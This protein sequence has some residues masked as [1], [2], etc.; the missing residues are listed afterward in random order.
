MKKLLAAL[1]AK[2]ILI[3]AAIIAVCMLIWFAGPYLS[4]GGLH[5]FGTISMRLT[6]IILI[7]ALVLFFL[8][9][10]PMSIIGMTVSCLLLWHASPLLTLGSIQPFAS[11]W[12]RIPLLIVI[13]TAYMLIVLAPLWQNLGWNNQF[14]QRFLKHKTDNIAKNELKIVNSI[15]QHAMAQLKHIRSSSTGFRRLFEGRKY[16]YELPWYM[17]IGTPGAGKTTALINSGMKFPLTEQMQASANTLTHAG[18]GG[19]THCDWWFTNDAVLIDTAGRY[20]S[21]EMDKVKDNAEWHGFLSMLRKRRAQSPINGAIVAISL[22][23]FL[24]QTE[25]E[26]VKHAQLLRERLIELRQEL[27]IRFPV[28][29]M[30]TKMDL[31]T[32]FSEYFHHL[33][34]E[35]LAQVWGFTL[36]YL[37]TPTKKHAKKKVVETTDVLPLKQR[38]QNE[39]TALEKRLEE[40][41]VTRLREEFDKDRRC[42]LYA[43]P[44]EFNGMSHALIQMIESIFT[45]SRFDQ[46]HVNQG[47]RGVYFTSAAQATTS[48]PANQ[49]SLLQRLH[50]AFSGNK[51]E[52]HDPASL[53]PSHKRSYFLS[54]L[55]SRI[56]IPDAHLVRPNLR[57]ELRFRLLRLISHIGIG[58][59]AL[60]L[61]S[62]F[63]FSFDKNDA[64]LTKVATKVAALQPVIDQMERRT[65]Y[66]NVPALSHALSMINQL[67]LSTEFDIHQPPHAV[68]YGL[69]SAPAIIEASNHLYA[70]TQESLLIPQFIH[71]LEDV[72][73]QAISTKNVTLAYDTLRVY[74]QLHQRDHFNAD[75]MK[76]WAA[77]DWPLTNKTALFGPQSEAMQH[78][79]KLFSSHRIVQSTTAPNSQLIQQVRSLLETTS[80]APHLYRSLKQHLLQAHPG[81]F[82]LSQAIG[83]EAETLFK[84][85]S[86]ALLDQSM[87]HIFTY[88]GF[89]NIIQPA[90]DQE[91]QRTLDE[92]AWLMGKDQ[93]LPATKSLVDNLLTLYLKEYATQWTHYLD[94]LDIVANHDLNAD[95]MVLKTMIKSSSPLVLLSRI[96]AHQTTLSVDISI[97]TD[98]HMFARIASQ[99][100]RSLQ[101]E[102]GTSNEDQKIKTL[103]DNQFTTLRE[104]V[105]GN[106]A[107]Y[108]QQSEEVNYS[109]EGFVQLLQ[110][111]YKQL[112]SAESAVKSNNLPPE[113]MTA[114]HKIILLTGNLPAPI[115]SIIT[116]LINNT[117]QQLDE[118]S[119]AFI[120]PQAQQVFNKINTALTPI[121]LSCQANIEHHYPFANN[122]QET[123]LANFKEMFAPGSATDKFFNQ[124]LAPYVD[125]SGAHWQ[126]KKAD[127]IKGDNPED[128]AT[129]KE[130]LRL[131]KK[132][133]PNP[134]DFANIYAIQKMFFA[135]GNQDMSFTNHIQVAE[136]D[137]QIP[138][139][140]INID[141]QIQRYAHGPQM[142]QEM[143]WPGPRGGV[144]A[145]VST[146]VDT[147][148]NAML[149]SGPWAI[150]RLL[151]KAKVTKHNDD[152]YATFHFGPHKAT[153]KL[154]SSIPL[155]RE[156][157][158]QFSCP[159]GAE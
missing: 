36:P 154:H 15:I 25:E 112:R 58:A 11:L 14:L 66:Q 122:Y 83:T 97:D 106:S 24:T 114:G 118:V 72:L 69:Y 91:V 41:L 5:P 138:E 3:I 131:L 29:I 56:I 71:Y 44:Q 94:D 2:Q 101:D 157:F 49:M 159:R 104:F 123:S 85:K 88:E 1:P 128:T 144:L 108:A 34:S 52:Q 16:L 55:F 75:D 70:H 87:P 116:Q 17:I 60:W 73:Q 129:K 79:I 96:V 110:E 47:L 133:G 146:A 37:P 8:Q 151:E 102:V 107:M 92:Q 63:V 27:G 68:G 30:I 35:D 39:F 105:T 76:T 119:S 155:T 9:A 136:L 32:G 26:R 120:R 139:L 98:N 64:Y 130:V 61:M 53:L 132:L 115:Q 46:T 134:E 62:A 95:M 28:Y 121:S 84:T 125:T 113:A 33:S 147:D 81:Y 111:Y 156:I 158:Q 140:M 13:L 153:L 50:R 51:S 90:I 38:L 137:P 142:T 100:N 86:G 126:Y 54:Q 23:D 109:P 4:F 48:L 6:M 18:Q 57:W 40:G 67:P 82:S 59:A 12:V 74:L 124:F 21:Q 65:D 135:N 78:L 20:S 10:W 19:T 149:A 152:T 117:T 43:L 7:M 150:Y 45:D 103:V 145:E 99:F 141:G 89:H 31:L 148:S 42:T 93:A 143:K 22:A 80:S 77:Q 127:E